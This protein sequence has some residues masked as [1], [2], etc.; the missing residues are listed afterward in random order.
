[1]D[2][3]E[4]KVLAELGQTMLKEW[5]RKRRWSIFFRII[6]VGLA[7]MLIASLGSIGAGTYGIPTSIA[8]SER[9]VGLVQVEGPILSGAQASA[10]YVTG[11]LELALKNKHVAG[12]I[13]EVNTPGGS[14]VQ[15]DQIAQA[16]VDLREKHAG[17]PI[18]I[19]I[20]EVCASGGMYIA[21]A[22]D[23][24]YA[25]PDSVV[26]S[27]G[28]IFGGFG[29]TEAI[30]SLGIERRLITAG[31]HKALFDPF[32]DEDPYERAHLQDLL[33]EIH[34]RFIE[35][36]KKG[37]GS[38]LAADPKLFS[39]LIWTGHKAKELG[40][41]DGFGDVKSVAMEKFETDKVHHYSTLPAWFDSFW[42]RLGMS[43]GRW[44][45]SVYA[46]ATSS[47]IWL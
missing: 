18:Y 9:H 12:I 36:V 31:E 28:V 34:A 47:F 32:E 10:H 15:S 45:Q 33:D 20:S 4:K 21:S 27:I 7:F 23:G 2:E 41:I 26:G 42:H 14:P 8:P 17:K 19:V 35:R 13:V 1:M 40:L 44:L 24:V 11:A 30:R 37:R 16:I 29:F 39:G 3:N 38:A 25:H 6:F 5:R 22:G 46:G 43:V